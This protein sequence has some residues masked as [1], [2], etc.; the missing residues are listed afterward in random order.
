MRTC[1]PARSWRAG[2]GSTSVPSVCKSLYN[3]QTKQ[4]P[5]QAD[6]RDR[7]SRWADGA[8]YFQGFQT[9]IPP[10]GPQ[11]MAADHWHD[12]EQKMLATQSYHPGGVNA[13]LGDGSVHFMSETIDAGDQNADAAGISS[14]PSPYGVWGAL[15]TKSGSESISDF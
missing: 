9:I 13:L 2:N 7:G 6:G 14:G 8:H 10:N 3:P 11:C 1:P 15:G 4:Y 12:V 5:N